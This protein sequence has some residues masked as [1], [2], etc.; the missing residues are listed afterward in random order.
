MVR[1]IQG[2]EV[3]ETDRLRLEPLRVPHARELFPLYQDARIYRFI[4]QE[5]PASLETLEA[6]CRRLEK[7]LSHDGRE[8]WLNWVVR[9]KETGR[10]MGRIEATVREDATAG[11]AY[12]LSP[13]FWGAGIATEACGRILDLL[14]GP[15]AVDEID[16][17]VDTRNASSIRL[18]ERLGFT[19]TGRR[20]HADFFKGGFSDEYAYRLLVTDPRPKLSPPPAGT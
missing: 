12:E 11:I 16:A 3:L 2:E 13:L 15:Y 17:L 19:R 18:L 1:V 7:R 9:S 14:F 5:P 20:D 8:A 4:P 10:V 6:R